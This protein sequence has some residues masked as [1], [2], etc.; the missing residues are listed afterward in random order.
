MT[1]ALRTAVITPVHGRHEHLLRQQQ[2]L[3]DLPDPAAELRIVVAMDDPQVAGL[4]DDA[5]VVVD[6]PTG[7]QGLAVGAA[8]NAGAAA[9]LAAGAELLVFLDVDC[10]PGP[11]T[12]AAYRRA[13]AGEHAGNLLAGAVAYLPPP[14]PGGYDLTR[15]SEHPAHPGRPAP[16][17]G[18]DIPGGDPRLFW[19]LSFAARAAVWNRIG[20][21]DIQ[22]EGYGAED[23]DFAYRAGRAGVGVTWVGG[24]DAYHQWHPSG[25]PPVRHLDDILRNGGLFA[26]RWGFWPMEGWLRQ[27][28]QLGLVRTTG[29]DPDLRWERT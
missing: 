2:A 28:E 6:G 17:P 5:A 8:R 14:P 22:F 11:G 26:R 21:F 15:L 20:G 27:F 12:L 7:R 13:A 29:A 18:T 23:T 4:V 9:A 3:R 1:A 16:A 25:T 19:S 24:A 10:L